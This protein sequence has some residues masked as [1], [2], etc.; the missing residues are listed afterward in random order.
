MLII[1][2]G[3]NGDMIVLDLDNLQIGYVF[4]DEL[5]ENDS[6]SSREILICMNCS[7]GEFYNNSLT[8]DGYPVD[9]F[10]AERYLGLVK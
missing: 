9:G 10:Q 1:G 8:I 7:F 6:I 5:W 4:H 3:L 2:S